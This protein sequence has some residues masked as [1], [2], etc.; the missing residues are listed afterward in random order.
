MKPK[1][2]PKKPTVESLTKELKQWHSWAR[3]LAKDL[4]WKL[5][6]DT[7][8]VTLQVTVADAVQDHVEDLDYIHGVLSK[9]FGIQPSDSDD[10]SLLAAKASGLIDLM[11][12]KDPKVFREYALDF[13]PVTDLIP[14]PP[15]T[16]AD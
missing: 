10:A 7:D 11:A 1:K 2:A 12:Q 6:R 9:A 5:P 3:S 13:S 8:R 15:P 4:G 16:A 14:P